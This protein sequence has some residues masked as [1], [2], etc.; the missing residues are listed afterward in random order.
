MSLVSYLPY[1][2]RP[3]GFR[4]LRFRYTRPAPVAPAKTGTEK[5]IASTRGSIR[6][7]RTR[8]EFL[9]YASALAVF[10]VILYL[11]TREPAIGN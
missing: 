8:R 7:R 11:L 6:W 4:F 2:C 9:L 5:E 10:A 3:C 1:R